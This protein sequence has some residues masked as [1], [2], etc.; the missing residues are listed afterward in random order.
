[1]ITLGTIVAALFLTGVGY[2]VLLWFV[3]GNRGLNSEWGN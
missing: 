1:M 3:R 2:S